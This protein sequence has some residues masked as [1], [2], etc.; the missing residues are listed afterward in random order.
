MARLRMHADEV[1]VDEPLVER[2]IATQMP[3]LSAL[4]LRI[5]EPWGTDHAIW[6]VG[7]ELVARLP[8][9]G[10]A[11]A[12]PRRD[13]EW[14]PRLATSVPVAVPEP[15]AL[16]APALG[17]PY[18]WAVHR[19]ISGKSASLDLVEPAEFARDLAAVVVALREVSTADGLPARGRARPLTE[20]DRATRKAI[21]SAAHLIDVDAAIAVWEDALA[22]AP[23]GSRRW[24]H[25]DLEGNC[26]VD[27][28]RLTGLIDWGSTCVGDPAV[29]VQ[30]VWSPL[31]TAATRDLFLGLVDADEATVARSRGAAIHQSC[32]ALPYYVGTHPLIVER[33]LHKLRTLGVE[34]RE[35]P[36]H[37]GD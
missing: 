20:Y 32:A 13:A 6:R 24:V 29:D 2:L 35:Y 22:A 5:V 9:I 3:E 28:G 15:V 21:R 26:I 7:D 18:D 23:A 11:A 31:F 19:W 12:Q 33:S 25:G 16:G 17:Y 37:A 8:R 4:P 1:D 36:G 14:L 34:C 10:W 27:A 30:V